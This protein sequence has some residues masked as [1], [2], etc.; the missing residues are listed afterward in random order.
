M[1]AI[2]YGSYAR[3]DYNESS[4]MDTMILTTLPDAEIKQIEIKLY[5]A[6][7]EYMFRDGIMISVN[8]KNKE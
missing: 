8:I 1:K 4:D 2:L 3:G 6:A 7:Y 5:D